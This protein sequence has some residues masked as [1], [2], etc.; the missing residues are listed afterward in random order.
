[1][2]AVRSIEVQ[3][4]TPEL[5]EALASA[6]IALFVDARIA[7]GD[8]SVQVTPIAP[9]GARAT[10]AH[11]SSPRTL[12]ALAHAIYGRHPRSWLVTVPGAEFSPG[13]GLSPIA[14]RGTQVALKRIAA[15][16]ERSCTERTL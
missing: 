14:R 4:L 1:M 16:I 7:D 13:I 2:P 5:A 9:S 10:L 3:Q 8:E 11:T 12:L 15:L 6:E